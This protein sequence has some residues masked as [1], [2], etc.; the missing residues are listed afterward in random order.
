MGRCDCQQSN[1]TSSRTLEN[2]IDR[3]FETFWP[4]HLP[5]P[6]LAPWFRSIV[7]RETTA[8]LLPPPTFPLITPPPPPFPDTNEFYVPGTDTECLDCYHH[9]QPCKYGSTL[10]PKAAAWFEAGGILRSIVVILYDMIGQDFC[11]TCENDGTLTAC[12]YECLQIYQNAEDNR[13]FIFSFTCC[14]V[15]VLS[16]PGDGPPG[17][18]YDPI[19]EPGNDKTSQGS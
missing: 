8:L 2:P 9:E 15:R 5:F 10:P 7:D 1:S 14:C 17:L 3:I 18:N 16:P 13:E 19:P 11:T 12:R 4:S 6:P